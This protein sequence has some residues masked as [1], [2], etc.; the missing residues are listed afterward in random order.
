MVLCSTT[1]EES[2]E[3]RHKILLC[4]PDIE[5]H[6][7]SHTSINEHHGRC[8]RARYRIYSSFR[9]LFEVLSVALVLHRLLIPS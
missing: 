5:T 6:L 2:A 1:E 4:F 8:F 7:Q 9:F 3:T